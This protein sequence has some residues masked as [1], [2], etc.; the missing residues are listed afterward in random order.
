MQ[1]FPLPYTCPSDRGSVYLL[2]WK[3]LTAALIATAASRLC[4][5]EHEQD[6]KGLQSSWCWGPPFVPWL[7]YT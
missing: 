1:T 6:L 2:S 3:C 5:C 7:M 4:N